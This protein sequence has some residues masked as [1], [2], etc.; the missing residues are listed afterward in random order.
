M[1]TRCCG[2]SSGKSSVTRFAPLV[3][4][5]APRFSCTCSRARVGA[6]LRSLGPRRGRRHRARAVAGRG[7][8]R[9]LRR[10]VPLRSGRRRRAVHAT[11]G[12][13]AR[14]ERDQLSTASLARRATSGDSRRRRRTRLRA[15][16]PTGTAGRSSLR[17]AAPRRAR[18]PP[19]GAGSR[20]ES[21]TPCRSCRAEG[22]CRDPGPGRFAARP[23]SSS[24]RSVRR[25][26]AVAGAAA[27]G[28]KNGAARRGGG[29]HGG[30][31]LGRLAR[32]LAECGGAPPGVVE[33]GA[34]R[35]LRSAEVEPVG[36]A[37]ID[38]RQAEQVDLAD[39]RSRHRP[40]QRRADRAGDGVAA[41]A[42]RQRHH[43]IDAEPAEADDAERHAPSSAACPPQ[44][45][46]RRS[47]R[48][49]SR[50]GRGRR[51]AAPLRAA[52]S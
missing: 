36:D 24:R 10:Q 22:R 51:A 20:S 23:R 18:T 11:A 34:Q 6:M 2:A 26:G 5:A 30:V 41:A 35:R 44:G 47:C 13:G 29:R 32:L 28:A 48:P 52:G 40:E 12:P 1:P 8:L 19:P 7:R 9:V 37:Q 46:R 49:G 16:S 15:R 3:G 4:A 45:R 42:L 27:G 50:A 17:A 33:G 14:L 31:A 38:Q 43:R 25:R 21:R 39:Q